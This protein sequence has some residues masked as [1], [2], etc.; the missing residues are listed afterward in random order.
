MKD[1][2]IHASVKPDGFTTAI[3]GKKITTTYPNGVWRAVPKSEREKLAQ[4]ATY[5]VTRHLALSKKRTL[6]YGFAPPP[7][8]LMY[9]YGLFYSMSEAPFEF[10][11]K[12]LTMDDVLRDVYNT[13]FSVRFA[14]TPAKE[15]KRSQHVQTDSK[16]I[17]MPLS[18]GKDSLLTFALS[19]EL[20]FTVYPLFFEEP[21]CTYQ[22]KKKRELRA[23]L[24]REFG[25]PVTPFINAL[26]N[27][28]QAGSM[29]WGWD[30]LLLQYTTLL[31]PY[32]WKHKPEY[33]FWSNEQS[34]NEH[35]QTHE[36]YYVN[37]T[38]EQ[39]VQWTLHLT[40]L[41]RSFNLNTTIVS[42]LEPVHELVILSIL[43]KRYPEIGKYQLSCDGEKT[44]Y[45]WC[46]RCFEC[47]RV[48]LF[49]MALGI[50]PKR[51]GLM[52]NMFDKKKKD[53]FYLFAE[54]K[55]DLNIVFQSYPERLLAFYLA[56]KRGV[57]GGLM[58]EFEK[59]L[60]PTV[61]KQKRQLS[62]KYLAAHP[63]R[64]IPEPIKSKLY[65]IYQTEIKKLKRDIGIT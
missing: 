15:T 14:N 13:E 30:M 31:M 52:D 27:L 46:G 49:F 2:A 62:A 20:G 47:A 7:M 18:F 1:I 45:R 58:D 33:F 34:T 4:T 38:H 50:E 41:L 25:V 12:N 60:L 19:R 26:G 63:S 48:Y 36:G 59:T 5:F 64:T 57:R 35:A 55:E 42:L 32:I 51:V 8:R 6:E 53:L 56:Y 29:M 21:T 10:T 65:A 54:K 9:D 40:N 23:G 39:S 43:H 16:T 11:E 17:V 3:D 37:Y 61:E 24:A 28:R 22:N 44:K